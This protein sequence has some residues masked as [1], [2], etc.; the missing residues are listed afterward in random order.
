MHINHK[1]QQ[2]FGP[3]ER[4][5]HNEHPD[6]GILGSSFL[7]RIE[8]RN[9]LFSKT[10]SPDPYLVMRGVHSVAEG[11]LLQKTPSTNDSVF[12]TG[13]YLFF[14]FR[15]GDRRS[16]FDA[17][18]QREKFHKP[19]SLSSQGW[20]LLFAEDTLALQAIL[21]ARLP[22]GHNL[23]T[24]STDIGQ[25][26]HRRWADQLL[27]EAHDKRG[28]IVN[29][30]QEMFSERIRGR[31]RFLNASTLLARTAFTAGLNDSPVKGTDY[32]LPALG[33]LRNQE[34]ATEAF[35]QNI[36]AHQASPIVI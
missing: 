12:L 16:I 15:G 19:D 8:S 34:S 35:L 31:L 1:Q 17:R 27:R 33:S 36:T 4:Q 20:A 18:K 6:P 24:R 25:P 32:Q 22:V 23:R 5:L 10:K 28:I 3:F 11:L 9:R 13:A 14:D 30:A 26:H 2:F 21:H 29:A 7:E